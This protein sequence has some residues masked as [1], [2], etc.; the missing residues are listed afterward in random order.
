L[1]FRKCDVCGDK[2]E[3]EIEPKGHSF[4]E[5]EVDSDPTC[6]EKGIE[7]RKCKYCDEKEEKEIAKLEHTYKLVGFTPATCHSDGERVMVCSTCDSK[8]TTKIEG[9]HFYRNG[10]CISCDKGT[11]IV[12]SKHN[13]DKNTNEEW[14]VTKENAQCLKVT[15][16]N[17]T[18]TETKYDLIYIYDGNGKLIGE[19]SGKTL[20]GVTLTI[21]G[22]TVKIKLT[23]DTSVQKYGFYATVT[24]ES[25]EGDTDFDGAV[26]AV[27]ITNVRYL[28]LYTNSAAICDIN[29]DGKANLKDL[30]RIKK[31]AVNA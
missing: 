5:W 6:T 23:S 26:N 17:E 18:E 15:F 28:I 29:G 21:S 30:V 14:T 2:E 20:A 24:P 10:K 12:E 11:Q 27:D 8:I 9:K 1:E 25:I 22:D 31:L 19:Y 3:R 13:Y 4:S 16:S 7:I